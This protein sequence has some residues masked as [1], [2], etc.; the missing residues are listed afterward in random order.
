MIRVELG[1][2]VKAGM[3]LYEIRSH[4]LC[5]RSRQ[6]LLDACRELKSLLGDTE[7]IVGLFREG[8]KNPSLTC[9]LS[10]GAGLTVSEGQT[11]GPR[12]VKFRPFE[13]ALREAAE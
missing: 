5:G 6:P 13:I 2:E 8:D 9:Q 3:W 4:R 10:V 12:F 1:Q 7:H 11:S